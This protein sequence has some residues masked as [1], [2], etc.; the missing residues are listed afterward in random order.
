M[1]NTLKSLWELDV[2]TSKPC[3]VQEI[4]ATEIGISFASDWFSGASFLDQLESKVMQNK[5]NSGLL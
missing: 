1:P 4:Q 3:K 5:Y 2:K